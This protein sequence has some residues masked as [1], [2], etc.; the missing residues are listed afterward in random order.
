MLSMLINFVEQHADG[1]RLFEKVLRRQSIAI[2]FQVFLGSHSLNQIPFLCMSSQ[3]EFELC[4]QSHSS[5][6]HPNNVQ[7]NVLEEK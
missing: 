4:A 1:M 7:R 5:T 3:H 2:V 6:A